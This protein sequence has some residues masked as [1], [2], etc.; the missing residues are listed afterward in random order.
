MKSQKEPPLHTNTESFVLNKW[1][2]DCIS[3]SG[4]TVI[5]YHGAARWKELAVRYS[6]LL[7]AVDDAPAFTQYSL[8]RDDEPACE[9][10]RVRWRS[11]HLGFEGTW[12][13]IDPG[14]SETLL[15]GADGAVEWHCLQ[16]R[17]CAEIQWG[18]GRKLAGLGYV[19]RIRM[20]IAPWKLPI[21]EL[22][23]GRFLNHADSV[24]WIDWRGPVRKR[25]LLHNGHPMESVEVAEDVVSFGTSSSLTFGERTILREGQLGAIALAALSTIRRLLPHRILAVNETKWRS[26]ARLSNPA[27]KDGWA[28]HEVVRWPQ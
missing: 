13:A 11:R 23:W 6:C 27:Q 16:P 25:L 4:D 1:Y 15:T 22:L 20:T 12:S 26:R 9:G 14:H 2:A 24:V 19:E 7:V 10:S 8:K 21:D 17:A 3:D 28:I 5:V 18:N